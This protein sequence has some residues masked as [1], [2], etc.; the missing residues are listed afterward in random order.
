MLIRL[1]RNI[2]IYSVI[3]EVPQLFLI[4][5]TCLMMTDLFLSHLQLIMVYKVAGLDDDWLMA[6]RGSQRGKVPV[7]Y[8]EV[9]E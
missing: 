3:K 6:E 7:T 1:M 4:N 9:L 2:N 5:P 8:L